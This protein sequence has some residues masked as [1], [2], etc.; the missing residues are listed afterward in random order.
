MDGTFASLLPVLNGH[1]HFERGISQV[2]EGVYAVVDVRVSSG[3]I[4]S[5]A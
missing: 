5:L 2:K 1:R 3:L 4:M